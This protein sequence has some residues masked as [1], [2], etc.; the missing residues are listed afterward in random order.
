MR[1]TRELVA[2][3]AGVTPT[4]VSCVINNTRPVS[5]EAR[6][7]V[8]QAIKKLNYVSDFASR[9]ILGKRTKQIVV[10]VDDIL[11]PFFASM[12]KEL[13]EKF[14]E[15]GY[16]LSISSEKNLDKN[17]S[18]FLARRIDAVYFC[19]NIEEKDQEK[20]N[21][22]VD[23]GIMVVVNPK[24]R[25]SGKKC[26]MDMNTKK[27]I[28]E[29]VKYLTDRGHKHIAFI[30]NFEEGHNLDDREET[31]V[32][33]ML[34]RGLKPIV[35]RGEQKGQLPTIEVGKELFIKA[36]KEN[37]CLTAFFGLDD[38]L[39]IGA[40][41][42]AKDLGYDVPKDVSFIGV[43]GIYLSS[44]VSPKLT[45]FVC[46]MKK[47]GQNVYKLIVDALDNEI[48]SG[49]VQSLTLVEGGSVAKIN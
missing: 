31:F 14:S 47:F 48:Y 7:K 42:Q 6:N 49:Y 25:F 35:V 40:M 23:N 19:S 39:A 15:E 18:V 24:I 37:P 32:N 20:L 28:Q 17:I 30:T 11:N 41:M 36:M 8:M 2:K 13:E 9:G 12:V 5:E 4:T 46:D 33:E 27:A 43:D 29:G 45:T 22:L 21:K 44:L 38:I 3:E 34:N 10:L 26:T 16:S 1:V